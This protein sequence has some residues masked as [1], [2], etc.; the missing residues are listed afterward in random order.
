[1]SA[2]SG[3]LVATDE[4]TIGS[5]PFLD[6]VVVEDCQSNG[7][8]PDP[9]YTDKSDW[10]EM[11]CEAND[12]PDQ[13]FASEANSRRRRRWFPKCT[14]RKYEVLDP[15]VVVITNQIFPSVPS[16]LSTMVRWMSETFC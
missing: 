4:P 5:E 1:M 15:S 10:R 14:G 9:P 13:I 12:L 2:G 6:A 11:F 16:R 8:F 3:E 7:R